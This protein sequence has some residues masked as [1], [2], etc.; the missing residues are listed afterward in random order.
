MKCDAAH[1]KALATVRQLKARITPGAEG[2]A[3]GV[4]AR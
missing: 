1:W 4:I 3:T 2:Q